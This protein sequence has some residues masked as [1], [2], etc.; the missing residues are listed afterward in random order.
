[1]RR[2]R[3]QSGNRKSELQN[4]ADEMRTTVSALGCSLV[5]NSAVKAANDCTPERITRLLGPA[6]NDK[7]KTMVLVKSNLMLRGTTGRATRFRVSFVFGN[8][9]HVR[10]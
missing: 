3:L 2:S 5:G 6:H 4:T 7:E 1:M 9:E 10:P 8:K